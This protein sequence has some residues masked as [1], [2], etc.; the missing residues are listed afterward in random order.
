MAK[1]KK[2]FAKRKNVRRTFFSVVRIKESIK[3]CDIVFAQRTHRW[4]S[5]YKFICWV[6]RKFSAAALAKRFDSKCNLL[7]FGCESHQSFVIVAV[8]CEATICAVLVC[9][10]TLLVKL[11]TITVV[12]RCVRIISNKF[13]LLNT[14]LFNWIYT[15]GISS[16]QQAKN[17][18]FASSV[19]F[20]QCSSVHPRP[21]LNITCIIRH[22]EWLH[23]Q[24]N[25]VLF[26][27][28]RFL[29]FFLILFCWRSNQISASDL[30]LTFDGFVYWTY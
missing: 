30:Y 18:V 29:A 4:Y 19:S 22:P 15:N 8:Q 13:K 7:L 1:Q 28:L 5:Y 12:I 17:C 26:L 16:I 9:T 11:C 2:I 23:C 21:G 6:N 14:L 20:L 10:V 24:L 25:F 3:R 27:F